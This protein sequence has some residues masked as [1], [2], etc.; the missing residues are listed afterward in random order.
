MSPLVMAIA[1]GM[2]LGLLIGYHGGAAV[3]NRVGGEYA[4]TPLVVGLAV[5]GAVFFLIP[6]TLFVVFALKN[7]GGNAAVLAQSGDLGVMAVI[8]LGIA[9]TIASGVVVAVFAGALCGRFAE[10][11][12]AGKQ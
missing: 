9:V 7:L 3:V 2:S 12:R 10:L 8:A 1:A 5:A 11:W 4:R 6:A